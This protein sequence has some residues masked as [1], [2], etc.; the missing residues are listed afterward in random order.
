MLQELG[1]AESS[2]GSNSWGV[3]TEELDVA[4]PGGMKRIADR[5]TGG[6]VQKPQEEE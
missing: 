3:V 4:V 1:K 6:K 5:L 2:E